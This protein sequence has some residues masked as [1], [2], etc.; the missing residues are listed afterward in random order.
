MDTIH[1]GGGSYLQTVAT[2]AIIGMTLIAAVIAGLVG[3]WKAWKFI[4][5][6]FRGPL[7]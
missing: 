5:A 3:L 6:F 1:D 7:T 2:A 4:A